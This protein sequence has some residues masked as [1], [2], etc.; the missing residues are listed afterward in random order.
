MTS[1][2][3]TNLFLKGWRELEDKGLPGNLLFLKLAGSHG[4]N[5]ST[6]NSDTDYLGV[7]QL[8]TEKILSI[9]Q[10]HTSYV[11]KDPDVTLHEVGKFCSLLLKGNPN[12]IEMLFTNRYTYKSKPWLD[13]LTHKK[14]FL[15]KAAV[16]QYL[17][18]AQGQMDRYL[19]GKPVHGT[20]G[21]PNSKWAYHF[22]RLLFDANRIVLGG[23]PIPWKEYSERE[24]LLDIRQNKL[25]IPEITG[26]WRKL[27][28]KV[29]DRLKI[30][31]LPDKG[32]YDLLNDWLLKCRRN[33]GTN[34]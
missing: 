34:T 4:H 31:G 5:V 13:L 16:K 32:N 12:I 30:C 18:Y 28:N 25:S 8:P 26:L 21:K 6:A 7:Y 3:T 24:L 15:S 19:K 11:T 27:I 33:N 9:H 23:E 17:G 10:E 14:E 2:E 29:A 22:M 1:I 20:G